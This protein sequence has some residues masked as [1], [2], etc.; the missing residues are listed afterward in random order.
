MT[1]N[2]PE[3]IR[4]CLHTLI[5]T[6]ADTG[7]MHESFHKDNQFDF[8][9]EWFAWANGLFGEL[10]LRVNEQFPEILTNELN[11]HK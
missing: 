6:T 3:E 4:E 5:S 2:D 9:R 8:T 10:I 1:S 7:F 11:L